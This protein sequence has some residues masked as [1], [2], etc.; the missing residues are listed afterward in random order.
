MKQAAP[1]FFYSNP[2]TII[3]SFKQ[4]ELIIKEIAPIRRLL[5]FGFSLQ[6]NFRTLKVDANWLLT[7]DFMSNLKINNKHLEQ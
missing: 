3:L 1:F 2:V 5:K 7:N 6:K 4:H